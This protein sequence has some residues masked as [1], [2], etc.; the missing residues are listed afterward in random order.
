V[1]RA[2]IA[3]PAAALTTFVGTYEVA[4]GQTL[5]VKAASGALAIRSNLGGGA[6]R[7]VPLSATAFYAQDADVEITFKE[8]STGIVTGL[9]LHQYGRDRLARKVK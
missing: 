9:V 2:T 6:V 5:D 8:D 1:P 4:P 7:A 3:L